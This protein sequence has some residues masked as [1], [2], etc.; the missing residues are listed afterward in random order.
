MPEF[1]YGVTLARSARKELEDLDSALVNRVFPL[2]ESLA[3]NPRP[4]GCK[5]LSGGQNLWRIRLGNYR[6]LYHIDDSAKT[7]DIVAVRHRREAYR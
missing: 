4:R 3:R 7:V 5:K 6:V 1:R 2:I